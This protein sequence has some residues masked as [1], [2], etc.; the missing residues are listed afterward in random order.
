MASKRD[1]SALLKQLAWAIGAI[2][3][4]FAAI[5]FAPIISHGG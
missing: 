3:L 5:H 1:T 2:A 4:V